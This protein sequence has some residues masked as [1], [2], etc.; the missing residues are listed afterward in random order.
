MSPSI[1][2]LLPSEEAALWKCVTCHA[3]R[4]LSEARFSFLKR[5]KTGERGADHAPEPD[6]VLTKVSSKPTF[7]LYFIHTWAMLRCDWFHR[8]PSM[9]PRGPPGGAS[10]SDHVTRVVKIL[11][12][13]LFGR[14]EGGGRRGGRWMMAGDERSEA[15]WITGF[16]F[17]GINTL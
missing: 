7:D 3:A 12:V 14:L 13:F 17:N 10:S 6:F 2:W 16:Y 9:P 11:P 15:G 5:R 4:F 8:V 1:I